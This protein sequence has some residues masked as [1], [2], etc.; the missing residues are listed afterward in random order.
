MRLLGALLGLS[1]FAASAFA[2]DL[3]VPGTGDGLDI[4]RALGAAYTA[5]HPETI[6]LTPPSVHSAGGIAAVREGHAV[7]GRIARALTAEEIADGLIATPVF[8]LPCTFIIHPAANVR[9]LTA[10][11]VARIFRG[12][13]NNWQE[14]GG[15]D[16]RIK[17]VTREDSDS[18]LRVLRATMPGWRDLEFTE[19]S[20]MAA[21]TQD[22]YELVSAIPGTIG[23]GPYSRIL[24]TN[25]IVPRIDGRHPTEAG[26]PSA[27]TLSL[28]YREKDVT[29]EALAFVSFLFS[30]K[31]QRLIED[32]GGV[33]LPPAKAAWGAQL[34]GSN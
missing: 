25:T 31:A 21:T 1:F 6:V 15:T 17:R 18:T 24:E 33:P 16:L 4:L 14:L 12:E 22:A 8:R 28:I 29:P 30:P 5:D 3:A 10:A 27:V 20:K 11:Q 7:L 2:G 32:F 26:Y 9:D 19:R 13:I 34:D 23:F